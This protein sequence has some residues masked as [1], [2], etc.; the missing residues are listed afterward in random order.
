[1][2]LCVGSGVNNDGISEDKLS[3]DQYLNTGFLNV[4]KNHDIHYYFAYS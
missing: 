4:N 1:M 3:E 2:N